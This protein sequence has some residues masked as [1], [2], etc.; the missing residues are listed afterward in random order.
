LKITD[1]ENKHANKI[2]EINKSA[3]ADN[4]MIKAKIGEI[5][6]LKTEVADLKSKLA[7]IRSPVVTVET[8]Q[9]K[10]CNHALEEKFKTQVT[11]L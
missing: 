6:A 4:D 10:A 8:N 3:N 9:F 7:E 2:Q 1:L 5:A 11:A